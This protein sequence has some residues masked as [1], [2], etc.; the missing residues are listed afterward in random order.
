MEQVACMM[1]KSDCIVNILVLVAKVRFSDSIFFK[2]NSQ[3]PR[4]P[5]YSFALY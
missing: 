3:A 5:T 1:M 4:D 2:N